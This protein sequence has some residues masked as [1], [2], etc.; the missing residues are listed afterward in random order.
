MKTY[1]FAIVIY[2]PSLVR[3]V[4]PDPDLVNELLAEL[5]HYISTAQV[6][7]PT[8]TLDHVPLAPLAFRFHKLQNRDEWVSW[9]IIQRLCEMG[10]EPFAAS[11]TRYHLKKEVV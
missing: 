8:R 3:L 7:A 11:A 5:R 4:L 2:E 9:W 10:W 1:K 6:A